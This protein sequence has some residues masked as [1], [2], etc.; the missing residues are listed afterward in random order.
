MGW[1]LEILQRY[2]VREQV[3]NDQA[4]EGG[5][6]GVKVVVMNSM[7]F[8][9]G[10]WDVQQR[11]MSGEMYYPDTKVWTALPDMM[12]PRYNHSLVVVQKRLVVIC[13]YQ[14][15]ETTSKVEVLDRSS[16]T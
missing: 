15:T 3:K 11:L 8:V 16:N 2:S 5:Q 14:G 10:G 12:V 13:G 1:L 4:H 6:V 9:V 7:L